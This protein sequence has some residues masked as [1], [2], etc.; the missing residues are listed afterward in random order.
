MGNEEWTAGLA[1]RGE[2]AQL[3]PWHP[4]YENAG[5]TSPAG[6]ATCYQPANSTDSAASFVFA[7]IRLAGHEV[8]HY[9][10]AA[11]FAMIDKFL[12]GAEW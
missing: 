2:L 1:A 12:S 10:P 9:R 3:K 8:P 11:G 5:R 6:Y 4:W 7:T